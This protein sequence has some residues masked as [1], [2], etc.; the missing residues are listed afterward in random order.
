MRMDQQELGWIV[1]SNG[2]LKSL[3]NC[4]AVKTS[5]RGQHCGL[6]RSA[7][8]CAMYMYV[9]LLLALSAPV[10]SSIDVVNPAQNLGVLVEPF[11]R[12]LK[13]QAGKEAR[14]A[15]KAWS[16]DGY[17]N[18]TVQWLFRDRPLSPTNPPASTFVWDEQRIGLSARTH[19]TIH[20]VTNEHSGEYQCKVSTVDGTRKW[21]EYMR[22]IVVYPPQID[23]FRE[24][25]ETVN[26]LVAEGDTFRIPCTVRAYPDAQVQWLYNGKTLPQKEGRAREVHQLIRT[27][28]HAPQKRVS[29]SLLEVMGFNHRDNGVYR[30]IS[31][32]EAGNA[33]RA[34]YAVVQEKPIII[35]VHNA[36]AVIGQ[37]VTLA[38]FHVQGTPPIT[39]TASRWNLED[40]ESAPPRTRV[41]FSQAGRHTFLSRQIKADVLSVRLDLRS[42]RRSDQGRYRFVVHNHGGEAELF[43]RLRVYHDRVRQSV[44]PVAIAGNGR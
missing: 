13:A 19:L 39:L 17:D 36:K 15:C 37:N 30:C 4:G 12:T 35:S 40:A 1:Q 5:T 29:E 14:L 32:N 23:A 44:L 8:L 43:V 18:I 26:F 16:R 3:Q 41:R 27:D 10:G 2:R 22:V 38:V 34:I 9:Y 24:D 21:T 25:A 31:V 20:S 28:P 7:M 42:V 11:S 6:L 33:T